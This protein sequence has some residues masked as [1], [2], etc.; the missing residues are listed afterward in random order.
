MAETGALQIECDRAREKLQGEWLI[1]LLTEN[2][3]DLEG[4]EFKDL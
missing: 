2:D 4:K 3:N 1:R